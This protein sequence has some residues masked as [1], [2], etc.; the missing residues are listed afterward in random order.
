[1][2]FE[3]V[4]WDEN[5]R[6]SNIEKHGLDFRDAIDVLDGPCLELSGRMVAG[7]IRSIA[8]G[9][10]DDVCVSIIYTIRGA[11]LRVISMRKARNGE[12]KR[13]CQ[14]FSG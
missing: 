7:E 6:L 4:E 5:K 12:R 10:L 9:M 14:I 2:D 13:Y 1:M 11:V 3:D 8:V